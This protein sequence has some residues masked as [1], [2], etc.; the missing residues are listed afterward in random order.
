MGYA[1]LVPSFSGS[2]GFG[3]EFLTRAT[4]NIGETD[5]K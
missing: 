1:I 4:G 5:A 2:A 3:Q